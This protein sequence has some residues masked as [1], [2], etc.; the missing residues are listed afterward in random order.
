MQYGWSG[1]GERSYAEQSG[2]KNERLSIVAG[3]VY[4]TKELLAP[5]EFSGYMNAGLFNAWFEHIFCP[6]LKPGQVIILDNASFHKLQEL[7]D[8]AKDAGCYLVFLPPYSPDLNP[9]E[10]VWAN[11]KSNLRRI[12]KKCDDFRDA[13]TQSIRNT[14]PC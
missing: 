9:I 13:I 12:I 2:F 3:Y 1:K 14:L 11:F 7:E 6:E 4:G 5:F 10:K 8:M